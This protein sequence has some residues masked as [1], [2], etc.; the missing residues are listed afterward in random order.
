VLDKELFLGKNVVEKHAVR[1]FLELR[2]P[3]L[4]AAVQIVGRGVRGAVP[5][6]ATLPIPRREANVTAVD[7]YMGRLCYQTIIK[8][9]R[10]EIPETQVLTIG[11]KHEAVRS[12]T[13]EG[14][15]SERKIIILPSLEST[16]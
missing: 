14:E 2:I 13:V 1:R 16:R 15:E 8:H 5:W 6:K 10:Q 7:G 3:T 11:R 9:L 12:P 4:A